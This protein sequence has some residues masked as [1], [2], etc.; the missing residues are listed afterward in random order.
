MG[1]P[2]RVG[3]ANHGT[4]FKITPEGKFSV[5]YSFCAQ[6][7][8]ADGSY[9]AASLIQSNNGNLYGTTTGGGAG[10]V[11]KI[12]TKG[13]LTTL[14]TFCATAN[15]A[16]GADPV[17]ELVLTAKGEFYGTTYNGGTSDHGTVFKVTPGGMLTTLYSF[18]AQANCTDGSSPQAGLVQATDGAFYGT[19][20]FGGTGSCYPD[21]C[22]TVFKITPGGKLR[23]IHSFDQTDGEIPQAGLVQATS[24]DLYGTTL[25]GGTNGFGTAFRLSV[26]L[27]PFVET[28]PTSGKVGANVIILGNNLTQATSVTFNGTP[29][30]FTVV[31]SSEIK[32]TVPAGATTGEV[33]VTTPKRLL[34]SNVIFRVGP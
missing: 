16:D 13:T 3:S 29:A 21:D 31:K 32:T 34:K 2:I 27:G 9:P 19:T 17:S 26:G 28:R 1:R 14:Y 5:L 30:A 22:G 33:E 20:N 24:G 4:V 12:T 15:C 6:T 18:C 11:F 8:C 23:T 25:G 10:T 7:N